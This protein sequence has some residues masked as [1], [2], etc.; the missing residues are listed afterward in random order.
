[1]RKSAYDKLDATRESKGANPSSSDLVGQL[2]THLMGMDPN[3]TNDVSFVRRGK[4]II[5]PEEM[6]I[7]QAIGWLQRKDKEDNRIVAVNERL[8]GIYPLDG[9]IA[10]GKALRNL[11][12]WVSNEATPGFW[13]DTPPTM[14]SVPTGPNPSTDVVQVPWSRFTVPNISGWLQPSIVPKV[15]YPTFVVTGE[16]KY[17][18]MV[19]VKALLDEVRRIVAEESIYRGKAI[20]VDFSYIRDGAQFD[21]SLNAP[22]FIG[23][24]GYT[25]E[26]LILPKKT[27]RLVDVNLLSFLERKEQMREARIPL[28]RG[29]LLYGPFGTGKT[30]T[31]NVAANLATKNG[32]TFIYLDDVRD[33][34]M[35][36][37]FAKQYQP[38]VVF[39]EDIDRDVAG[40]RTSE[41]DDVLNTIDGIELKNTEIFTVLTSN[42]VSVIN[43]AMLRPG[44]LDAII[45]IP[46]HDSESAIRLVK[47]YGGEFLDLQTNFEPV[48]K[49]LAGMIPASIREVVERSKAAAV[50]DL[51]SSDIQGRVS[52][53][54]LLVSAE[55]M[56]EHLSLLKRNQDAAKKPDPFTRLGD[57]AGLA[58]AQAIFNAQRKAKGIGAELHNDDDGDGTG[59]DE[60]F[61]NTL[62]GLNAAVGVTRT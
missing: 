30:L 57:A 27:E 61:T 51:G 21:I 11:F 18:D 58:L 28:K 54:H 40:E 43:P 20:K 33:L 17:K 60:A 49:A 52:D 46:A 35:A 38:A 37:R 1:M 25:R 50:I 41:M 44:R 8:D 42:D 16:V 45:E 24:G 29:V 12:G 10:L 36:L 13:G 9:A 26:S 62:D 6:D 5:L 34:A 31:A 55:S 59:N 3:R 14:V 7:P 4:E 19:K 39:S 2:M 56:R 48:G 23:V 47:L 15:N 32:W 53:K 22:K